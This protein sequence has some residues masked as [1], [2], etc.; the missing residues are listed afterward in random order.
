MRFARQ[1][2]NEQIEIITRALWVRAKQDRIYAALSFA[3][4]IATGSGLVDRALAWLR[5]HGADLPETLGVMDGAQSLADKSGAGRRLVEAAVRAF[6]E[7]AGPVSLVVVDTLARSFSG[8]NENAQQDMGRFVWAVDGIRT[9]YG[10]AVLVVQ[11]KNR[12]GD[13]RGPSVLHGALDTMVE[14]R[15]TSTGVVLTCTKQK[16][17]ESFEDVR[18]AELVVTLDE[19]NEEGR[20]LTSLVFVPAAKPPLLEAD[21]AFA[22]INLT[23]TRARSDRESAGCSTCWRSSVP[24]RS[25]VRASG[26]GGHEHE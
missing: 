10:C 8:G 22:A 14:A 1:S 7:E 21:G 5:H 26:S 18:L 24:A 15:A 20:P 2:R 6:A 4:S 17:A 19:R 3:L 25:C 13:Y 9:R 11:H 23:P 16:D 12:Q